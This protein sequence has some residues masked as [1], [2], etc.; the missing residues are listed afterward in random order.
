MQYSYC[1]SLVLYEEILSWFVLLGWT[2]L[3]TLTLLTVS[4]VDSRLVQCSGSAD[5]CKYCK[6]K[7][8]C[9]LQHSFMY[10]NVLF[11]ALWCSLNLCWSA[12]YLCL[13]RLWSFCSAT[14]VFCCDV[15]VLS[16]GLHHGSSS[17]SEGTAYVSSAWALKYFYAE[18]WFSPLQ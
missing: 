5:S 2:T 1:T 11:W 8:F 9:A 10:T 7:L 4:C 16:D 17:G 12:L 3:T 14:K 15:I 13:Y 18:A 6:R